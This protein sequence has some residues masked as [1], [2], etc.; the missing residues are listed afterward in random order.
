M[1]DMGE[2]LT[3]VR[4]KKYQ[5][6]TDAVKAMKER[7]C[8][9]TYD[10]YI[11]L[12]RGKMPNKHQMHEVCAFFALEPNCWF[13][14]DCDNAGKHCDIL[15][16]LSPKMKKMTEKILASIQEADNGDDSHI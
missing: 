2:I 4:Y 10:Q 14:G 12:E 11:A 6:A 7:G 8:G 1:I 15:D 5:H 16:G 13:M 3:Q 9:I